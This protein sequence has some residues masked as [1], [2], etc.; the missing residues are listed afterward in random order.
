MLKLQVIR[1][2]TI[3]TTLTREFENYNAAE[4]YIER[5]V[6]R[7]A[8]AGWKIS[9]LTDSTSKQGCIECVHDDQADILLIQWETVA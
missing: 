1:P 2:N 6:E 5:H 9:E 8:D 7:L 3:G 4:D